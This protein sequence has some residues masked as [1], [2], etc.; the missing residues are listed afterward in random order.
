MNNGYDSRTRSLA[1]E[2][3]FSKG[4]L[5]AAHLCSGRRACWF[6]Q[7]LWPDCHSSKQGWWVV[8]RDWAVEDGEIRLQYTALDPSTEHR[9]GS[10][11]VE[12]ARVIVQTMGQRAVTSW[13]S[14]R[15][16]GQDPS[17]EAPYLPRLREY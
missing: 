13:M 8:F 15:E 12:D 11:T 2:R 5:L 10:I 14:E 4:K 17:P 1:A 6:Y 3:S 16:L 7:S 9:Q